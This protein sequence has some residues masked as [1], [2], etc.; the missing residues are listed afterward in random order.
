MQITRLCMQ[1]FSILNITWSAQIFDLETKYLDNSNPQGNALIGTARPSSQHHTCGHATSFM[2]HRLGTSLLKLC[3]VPAGYEGLVT[4]A[5]TTQQK[6]KPKS[7]LRLFSLSSV[8][9]AARVTM[10]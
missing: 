5:Q 3:C 1:C 4:Q 7:D 10:K 9:G 6:H 8:S 2:A